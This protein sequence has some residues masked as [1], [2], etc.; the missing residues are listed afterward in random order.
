LKR[1]SQ[2]PYPS[3]NYIKLEENEHLMG[4]TTFLDPVLTPIM[5]IGSPY[6]LILM[7]FLITGG[8][9]LVYKFAT[10]QKLMKELKADMK[11]MQ[12]KMKKFRDQPEKVMSMQ[13]EAMDKNLKYMMQ[14]LKPTLIT[15]IP[16][17]FIFGWL[18][19]Y[20]IAIGEPDVLFGLGWFWSY[21]I[22]TIVLSIALRKLL[23][24]H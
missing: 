4:Y 1:T 19:D 24:V 12:K 2:K 13:K 5:T 7:A 20:Y 14:S 6:N 10:D 8:I 23:N 17:I 21:F 18:R 22:V 16:I 15:F 9:T 3:A 11:S